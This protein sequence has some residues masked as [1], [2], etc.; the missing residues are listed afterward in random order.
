[1]PNSSKNSKISAGP[2]VA[3]NSNDVPIGLNTVSDVGGTIRATL[4]GGGNS[5]GALVCLR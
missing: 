5:P 2:K 4:G 1:M 3:K